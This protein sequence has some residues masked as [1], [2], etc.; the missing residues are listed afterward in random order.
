MKRTEQ[1]E[2]RSVHVLRQRFRMTG[3]LKEDLLEL[4]SPDERIR[5][6]SRMGLFSTKVV[7]LSEHPSQN[8]RLQIAIQHARDHIFRQ[9]AESA[10]YLSSQVELKLFE[11]HGVRVQLH[12][13]N[14][15]RFN[16]IVRA[17][18]KIPSVHPMKEPFDHFLYVDIP[19]TQL[20]EAASEEDATIAKDLGARFVNEYDGRRREITPAEVMQPMQVITIAHKPEG[21]EA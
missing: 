4:V 17:Y 6:A 9:A 14:Q 12:P 21:R 19:S 7:Y 20:Y 13:R 2:Y 10:F 15:Q 8:E 5:I 11:G 3:S 18:D 1:P 16:H